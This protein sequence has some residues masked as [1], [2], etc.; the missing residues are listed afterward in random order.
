MDLKEILKRREEYIV[1]AIRI[2]CRL[3]ENFF[4][5]VKVDKLL[6]FVESLYNARKPF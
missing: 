3:N 1:T 4:G 2:Y 6:Q 5:N